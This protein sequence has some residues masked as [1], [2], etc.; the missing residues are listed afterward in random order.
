MDS[1]DRGIRQRGYRV[2]AKK[3]ITS[4]PGRMWILDESRRGRTGLPPPITV[5]ESRGPLRVQSYSMINAGGLLE[6]Y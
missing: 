4:H 2:F 3:S 6:F 1:V 5:N